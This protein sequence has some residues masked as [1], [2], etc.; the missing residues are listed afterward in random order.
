MNARI[1]VPLLRRRHR[2]NRRARTESYAVTQ[3]TLERGNQPPLG[4]ERA[5]A[6]PTR[7]LRVR[8]AHRPGKQDA[9]NPLT[10]LLRQAVKRRRL[11][12]RLMRCED[13]AARRHER[14]RKAR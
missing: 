3:I 4:H 2:L 12:P 7:V 1:E 14:E 9:P 11:R 6:P 10:I 13:S 8:K 5:E